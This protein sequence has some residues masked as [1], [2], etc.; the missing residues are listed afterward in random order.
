MNLEQKIDQADII[1]FDFFD[2]LFVR[3]LCD[4]EDAFDVLAKTLSIPNFRA[5]RRLAQ[6][7]AF[8]VMISEQ[9]KEIT[10]RGIYECFPPCAYSVEELVQA[11]YDVELSLIYPNSQMIEFYHS[12]I[13][14][15]KAVIITSD[16]YFSGRFFDEAL[17]K[18][19][20]KSA[21]L[22]ISA[23][24]NATKRD[25]GELFDLIIQE[26]NAKPESIL[27]IG[28]NKLA[29]VTQAE[30][31]GLKAHHYRNPRKTPA[32]ARHSLS[33]SLA[34]GLIHLHEESIP[35]NTC[36]EAGFFY[37]GPA[38]VGF[39]QWIEKKAQ[40]D[41]LDHVLFLAR[42]GYLL[43]TLA[44]QH[45]DIQLPNFDYFLGSRTAFT[46][47][48]INE[49]N[50]TSYIPYFMSGAE[51][52]SPFEILE[53]IGVPAP[54][55]EVMNNLGLSDASQVDLRATKNLQKF[56]YAYRWEIL[57]VCRRNRQGLLNYLLSLGIRS[58]QKVALVDVG[59]SGSTQEAFVN[60]LKGLMNIDV[61]GYYFCL[62]NT[63]EKVA[64]E[65]NLHMS[66][67]F[68][69]ATESQQVI[70]DI[71]KNRVTIEM[72][73]SAPHDTIIG[74]ECQKDK[75]VA[76]EDAGRGN[77]ENTSGHITD[78]VNG[79]AFFAQQY[80]RLLASLEIKANAKDLSWPIIDFAINSDWHNLPAFAEITN[81]DTWASTAN[82]D[83][84][85]LDYT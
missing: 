50:F 10:L 7:D 3:P 60:A 25:A 81:F 84:V 52:L 68:S 78:I 48:A 23:D 37:G 59:W 41:D 39:L 4:P 5:M 8:Q 63:P 79:G 44:E 77:T 67:L 27:H 6:K 36:L 69:S 20:V 73:F 72:F 34:R 30:S 1:S 62:A 12:A 2:T 66:A 33:A 16:M 14:A 22:F 49:H 13:D 24:A 42:D 40:E 83:T 47:A 32:L 46:L 85:A 9:K 64:R 70:D 43:N 17:T 61:H 53:R 55:Q 15:G 75:I 45:Q 21:P 76:I 57:K 80:A 58:G 51:G 74:L 56:L 11:E 18:H 31:R 19:N 82:R 38:S 29:D 35:E 54:N 71:Y 28:D 26:F 65:K